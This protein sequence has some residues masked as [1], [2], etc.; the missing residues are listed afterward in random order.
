MN[1]LTKIKDVSTRYDVTTRT[2]RYYEKMG[3][4][5][6]TRC[7][8]SGYRLY[9]ESTLARLKQIL[10]LRKMSISIGDIGRIFAANN[11]DTMLAVLDQKVDDIDSEAALLHE[12]KEFVLD[13][14]RKLRQVNF[15]N[16]TD[17]KMLFDQVTEIEA[18]LAKDNSFIERLLDTSDVVDEQLTSIAVSSEPS[19][20]SSTV[21][22]F[23]YDNFEIKKCGPYRFIGKSVYTRAF[24]KKGSP[25]IH[26]SF[27]KQCDWVFETLDTMKEFASDEVH[28]AALQHWE[29]F[30]Q[31]HETMTHWPGQMLF[32]GNELL[33]Y[34]IG[35][36]MK[37]DTP[38]PED[39]DYIDISEMYVAKGWNKVEPCD[40]IGMPDEGTMFEVIGQTDKFSSASWM[41][42]ADI[43]PFVDK[44]G[45][46]I[47]GTF[48]ACIEK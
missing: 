28:N 8:S 29:R 12:L 11:A 10:I 31:P 38:V 25:A 19:E 41:F 6:S 37:A 44:N 3:L 40:D 20:T 42:A 15:H 26:S 30:S 33:G 48:M 39:M 7:K 4:I 23:G 36:F 22:A 24:D 13:F 34:T 21:T 17:V 2:L 18:T 14:I 45:N 27:R 32:W 1:D 5:Q 47:R 9:D 46:L 35:R 43:F 16:E